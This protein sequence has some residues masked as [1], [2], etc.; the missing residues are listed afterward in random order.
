MVVERGG[1]DIRMPQPLL[2]LGDSG[3]MVQRIGGRS[4]AQG[5]GPDFKPQGGRVLADQLVNSIRR[6]CL[7]PTAPMSVPQRTE[8]GTLVIPRDAQISGDTPR[9]DRERCRG[10]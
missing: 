1:G 8:E 7:F 3:L 10:V 9:P 6:D 2:D 4:C 5:V